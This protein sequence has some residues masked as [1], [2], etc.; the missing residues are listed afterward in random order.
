MSP[1]FA[2][3]AL[4]TVAGISLFAPASARAEV[5]NVCEIRQTSDGW[6]A[7]RS[8]PGTSG[9]VVARMAPG[10]VLVLDR[11]GNKLVMRGKWYRASYF[12][13]EVMPNPGD[14]GHDKIRKGWVHTSVVGDCG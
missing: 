6:V 11:T 10:H 9:Q 3:A 1:N 8:T 2:T 12:P 4:V 13:G 5:F 7:L 14:P